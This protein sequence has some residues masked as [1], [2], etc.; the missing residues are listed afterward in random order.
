MLLGWIK[1]GGWIEGNREFGWTW[2]VGV[3]LREECVWSILEGST[4]VRD[5]TGKSVRCIA[6]VGCG[7]H[8]ASF[9]AACAYEIFSAVLM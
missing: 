4:L 9:L 5:K 1:R 3:P 6:V 7:P 8:E 2:G